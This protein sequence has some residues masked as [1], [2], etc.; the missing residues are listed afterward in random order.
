[1]FHS[2]QLEQHV[3]EVENAVKL[4]SNECF[5]KNATKTEIDGFRIYQSFERQT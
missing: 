5:C 4:V 1:M 2:K 3:E